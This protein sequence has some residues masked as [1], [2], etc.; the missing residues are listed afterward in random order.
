MEALMEQD[1]LQSV[2]KIIN[3]IY[4]HEKRHFLEYTESDFEYLNG[5]IFYEID[6]VKKWLDE[7]K[8]T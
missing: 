5:H 1:I 2:D 6:K 7:Q 8:E 3:Y 4:P